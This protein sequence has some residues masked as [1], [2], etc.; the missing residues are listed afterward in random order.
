MSADHT[1]GERGGDSRRSRPPLR[2]GRARPPRATAVAAAVD[3]ELGVDV[4]RVGAHGVERDEEPACDVRPVEVGGEQP[5]HLQL[6]R[7]QRLDEPSRLRPRRHV[8]RSDRTT[9]SAS[10]PAGGAG[11]STTVLALDECLEQLGHR[12]ALADEDP[13]VAVSAPPDAAPAPRGASAGRAVRG[14]RSPASG[15]RLQQA[16][17]SIR[18]AGPCRPASAATAR[19]SSSWSAGAGPTRSSRRGTEE[20]GQREVLVLADVGQ[21]VVGRRAPVLRAQS[22]GLVDAA[23]PHEHPCP[24][25]R[26]G[27]HVGGVVARR[28]PARPPRAGRPLPPGRPL[29][30]GA[31]PGRPASGRG[32]GA[33]RG[34]HRA[35]AP[36]CRWP[37]AVTRSPRSK[38]IWL[39][40]TSMSARASL[41]RAARATSWAA[42]SRSA[43]S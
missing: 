23:Q 25:R 42:A 5:E 1:C 15:Q 8:A 2:A 6:A 19:R 20:P 40:P 3:A 11:R 43:S 32:T 4:L 35:V 10:A 39:R 31:A 22:S 18:R 34:A 28:R 33:G 26:D 9:G 21:V 12:R 17:I 29:P 41:R 38:A 13:H 16:R 37:A 7:A 30:R 24:L 27:S 36:R 14:R